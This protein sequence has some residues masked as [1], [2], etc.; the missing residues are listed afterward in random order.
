MTKRSDDKELV[1]TS[2]KGLAVPDRLYRVEKFLSTNKHFVVCDESLIS[3][4]RPRYSN[5]LMKPQIKEEPQCYSR[6][7]GP[8]FCESADDTKR[9]LSFS[10]KPNLLR[11]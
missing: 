2:A 3:K 7:Y 5:V 4:E 8:R 1:I 10:D 6:I 9:L 11:N